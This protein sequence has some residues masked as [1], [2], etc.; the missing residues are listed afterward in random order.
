MPSDRISTNRTSD[1]GFC[2]T[3]AGIATMTIGQ[4]SDSEM[5]VPALTALIWS[6]TLRVE[7]PWGGT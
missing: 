2:S 3:T 6:S 5:P 4:F 1:R 7:T